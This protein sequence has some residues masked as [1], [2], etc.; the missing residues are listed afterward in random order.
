MRIVF[1]RKGFD[2]AAGGGASPIINGRAISLPIP[3]G[4]HSQ[5]SY[6]DLG[7]GDEAKRASRGR[8][9]DADLCHHD[10][11]FTDDGECLF[12]QCGAAQTHLERQGVGVGDAFVFFGLFECAQRAERHHRIF[13]FME[14]AE[15]LP[16][17]DNPRPDLAALGHPHALGMHAR[18]DV[19]YRGPGTN[20]A[21]ASDR[22]RLTVPEGPPSMWERPSWLKRGGL[23]YHDRPSRWVRGGRLQSVA[24]GQEFVANVGQRAAPRQWLEAIKAEI[25]RV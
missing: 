12:G 5:T 23:T 14:V 18:N 13:G 19:I 11:M 9:A 25:K 17:A 4:G 20:N 24:R 22:L 2:S 16:L 21:P 6:G 10:P 1:S 8:L 7:L 15:I 3:T